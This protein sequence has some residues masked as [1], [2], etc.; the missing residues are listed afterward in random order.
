MI[1]RDKHRRTGGFMLGCFKETAGSAL[2]D[3]KFNCTILVGVL[4]DRGTSPLRNRP[5]LR[6]TTAHP[7]GSLLESWHGHT[8]GFY[9]V[10][11]SYQR[12]T[13]V[14][15]HHLRQDVLEVQ[16]PV[17]HKC[18]GARHRPTVGSKAEAVPYERGTPV[19]PPSDSRYSPSVG[20]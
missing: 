4:N 20:F 17:C 6:I 12:G 11:F 9:G 13:P 16:L 10:A 14:R 1:I 2:V 18:M 19:G 8:A 15:M 3:T 7:L 5:L